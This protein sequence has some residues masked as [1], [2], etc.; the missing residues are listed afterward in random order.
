HFAAQGVMSGTQDLVVASGV[1]N[2]GMVPM[3]ANVQFAIDNGLG[4]YGEGW[5]ERY[6]TQEISQFRGAQLMCEK[7][8][9]KRAQLEEFSLESHQRAA[10]ALEAG[11]FDE[12]I[13]PMAGVERD[14]GVRPDTTLEKMA[15]LKPLREGWELTA[16]VARSE[17]RRVGKEGRGRCAAER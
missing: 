6:G 12:Q 5:D 8:G 16:A 15:A 17:E 1:E 9:Y 10:K 2:M 4:L 13:A 3:G 11:Y 14:E 7:W